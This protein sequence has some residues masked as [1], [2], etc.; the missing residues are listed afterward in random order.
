MNHILG[1]AEEEV[2][3]VNRTKHEFE[4]DFLPAADPSIGPCVPIGFKFSFRQQISDNDIQTKCFPCPV[5]PILD[6]YMYNHLITKADGFL[7]SMKSRH[8]WHIIL[9]SIEVYWDPVGVCQWDLR[10]SL[11]FRMPRKIFRVLVSSCLRLRWTEISLEQDL[12]RRI[13]GQN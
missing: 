9:S 10:L 2:Q 11:A 1:P 8:L 13:A 12:N 7:L 5:C 6:L 3:F 4:R